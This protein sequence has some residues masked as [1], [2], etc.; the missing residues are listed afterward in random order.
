M[1]GFV[2]SLVGALLAAL[3]IGLGLQS[4][5]LGIITLGLVG[6]TLELVQRLYSRRSAAR[7]VIWELESILTRVKRVR[8]VDPTLTGDFLLP[9]GEWT[10]HRS[11]LVRARSFNSVATA[12][13]EV[14]RVN[15]QW[16]W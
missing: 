7:L 4:A 16:A 10:R 1:P 2:W 15:D 6:I 12:Y 9:V 13:R 5:F 3:V 8:D 11:A 14:D